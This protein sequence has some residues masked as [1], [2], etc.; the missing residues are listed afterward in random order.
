MEKNLYWYKQGFGQI[1]QSVGVRTT[2][3][4]VTYDAEF[5]SSRFRIT[6][7]T[8]SCQLTINQIKPSDEAVYLCGFQRAQDIGFESG[9]FLKFQGKLFFL[10]S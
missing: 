8:N 5:N 4:G 10:S 6:E 3:R 9:A 2:Y 7:T 1:P